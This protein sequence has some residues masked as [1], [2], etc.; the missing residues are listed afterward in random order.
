MGRWV[1]EL[2]LLI[3][4]VR[5]F[6]GGLFHLLTLKAFHM[7]ALCLSSARYTLVGAAGLM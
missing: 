4:L 6:L 1:I 2:A 5:S 7:R 3:I